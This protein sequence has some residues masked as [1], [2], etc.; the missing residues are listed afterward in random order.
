[1]ENNL[2]YNVYDY[3]DKLTPGHEL[4]IKHTIYPDD[5]HS[6]TY[7]PNILSSNTKEEIEATIAHGEAREKKLFEALRKA[8]KEWEEQAALTAYYKEALKMFELVPIKHTGNEWKDLYN[9][10]MVFERSNTVYRFV[11]RPYTHT[12]WDATA[13]EQRPVS[14]SLYWSLHIHA[15]K[16]KERAGDLFEKIAGQEKK[17]PTKE[18]ME[19]YLNGRIKAYDHLFHEEFPKVP[20]KYADMFMFH[21]M[22][23]PGYELENE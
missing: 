7:I 2:K 13:K 8:V 5:K 18:E 20:R 23:K 9:D 12:K 4:E 10:G 22:M 14:Y 21:G 19:K 15:P 1:M 17:F 3:A 6:Q 16:E 11:Y